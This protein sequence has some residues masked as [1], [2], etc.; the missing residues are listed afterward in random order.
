MKTSF[1][2]Q[3]LAT[4]AGE[5]PRSWGQ[6]AEIINF[7][8]DP[9]WGTYACYIGGLGQRCNSPLRCSQ[10]VPRMGYEHHAID[11]DRTSALAAGWP[12]A[13]E[14]IDL[15]KTW[16]LEDDFEAAGMRC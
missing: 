8:G 10:L 5:Y 1:S 2:P 12:H 11:Y 7:A 16:G 14:E 13:G 3:P 9:P 4:V 15:F 6:E